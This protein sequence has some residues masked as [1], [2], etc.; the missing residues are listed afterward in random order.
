MSDVLGV[1]QL[2]GRIFVVVPENVRPGFVPL[3]LAH[4]DHF[5]ACIPQRIRRVDKDAFQEVSDVGYGIP[6][7]EIR[8][9]SSRKRLNPDGFLCHKNP[10]EI[11]RERS[12]KKTH[13]IL[14]RKFQN[15]NPLS[16]ANLL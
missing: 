6:D 9:G 11:S 14:C 15:I 5:T 3:R 7:L 12:T 16:L 10:N 2:G 4:T 13:L 8:R 1:N